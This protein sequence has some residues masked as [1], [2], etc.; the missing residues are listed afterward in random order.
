M[1]IEI[2]INLLKSYIWNMVLTE[3][4]KQQK[5]KMLESFEIYGWRHDEYFI[6][7]EEEIFRGAGNSKWKKEAD[8]NNTTKTRK[9]PR[10]R[11]VSQCLYEGRNQKKISKK[12]PRVTWMDRN[13]I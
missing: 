13:D 7:A 2:R 12:R 8:G 9:V 1:K 4:V 10:T 5:K 3:N 11:T 6:G